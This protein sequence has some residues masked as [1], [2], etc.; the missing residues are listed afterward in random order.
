MPVNLPLGYSQVT[1][2]IRNAASPRSAMISYVVQQAG[3]SELM[4]VTATGE[5]NAFTAAG[6]LKSVMDSGA[7]LWNI[8]IREG[9]S[10]AS[11]NSDDFPQGIVG[12]TGLTGTPPNCSLL[13]RK[14]TALP[15]RHGRGRFFFPFM[16]AATTVDEAGIIAGATLTTL[17]TAFNTWYGQH[18]TSGRGMLLFHPD[19][20]AGG[21]APPGTIIA[22]AAPTPILD[23]Q[24]M[25]LIGSQ[26]RRL[27]R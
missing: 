6:S 9:S 27:G 11:T 22:G 5:A 15:G 1:L 26:R 25:P 23:L 14:K 8:H 13:V 21:A 4:S 19:R 10:A 16:L 2:M 12:S 20:E 18:T 7:T 3:G 17:Q 24:C